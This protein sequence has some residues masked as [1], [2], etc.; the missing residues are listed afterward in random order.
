[1]SIN[2]ILQNP[3]TNPEVVDFVVTTESCRLSE[4]QSFV[5]KVK[6]MSFSLRPPL[7][8]SML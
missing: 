4:V 7:L 1:V 6:S 2:S 8:M 3:I 5:Y